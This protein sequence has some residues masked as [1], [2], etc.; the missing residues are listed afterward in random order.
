MSERV[1]QLNLALGKR[2]LS[3]ACSSVIRFLFANL[4][5][6]VAGRK[7]EVT[8]AKRKRIDGYMMDGAMRGTIR[9]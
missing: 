2:Q 7:V 8:Y 6:G 5:C 4:A 3:W 1:R 9:R